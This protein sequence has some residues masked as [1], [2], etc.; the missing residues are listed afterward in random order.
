VEDGGSSNGHGKARR[1][2]SQVLADE[3]IAD[4]NE[5]KRELDPKEIQILSSLDR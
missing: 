2:K 1:T 3:A 5:K 4:E